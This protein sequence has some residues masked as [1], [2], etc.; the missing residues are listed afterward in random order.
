MLETTKEDVQTF[1]RQFSM[2]Q[3]RVEEAIQI[4][5][6]GRLAEAEKALLVI[7]AEAEDL[8]GD[9]S[10]HL[11]HV[12]KPLGIV[13]FRQGRFQEAHEAFA[14]M[15]RLRFEYESAVQ[16]QTD[17]EWLIQAQLALQQNADANATL[18]RLIAVLES[19]NAAIDSEIR[20]WQ[21]QAAD[22]INVPR[23]LSSRGAL[24]SMDG[25][26]A[27]R[28]GGTI[29]IKACASC[30]QEANLK[31]CGGCRAAWFCSPACQK[32]CW[33]A[34]KAVCRSMQ[35]KDDLLQAVSMNVEAGRLLSP[36]TPSVFC[37]SLRAAL[38]DRRE[39]YFFRIGDLCSS[40][41]LAQDGG[42]RRFLATAG[43]LTCITVFAWAPVSIPI[44][45]APVAVAAH[46]PLCSV[47]RGVRACVLTGQDLDRAL[48]PLTCELRRCFRG[49]DPATVHVTLVGGHRAS[50]KDPENAFKSIL[51]HLPAMKRIEDDD[52]R[53]CFSWYVRAACTAAGLAKAVFDVRF[54]NLFE[55][56]RCVDSSIELRLRQANMRFEVAALDTL[57]GHVVTHT[58]HA[59]DD[60]ILSPV[61]FLRQAERYNTLPLAGEPLRPVSHRDAS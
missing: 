29:I 16:H 34:H 46:V 45:G 47:L 2:L 55:G 18:R 53:M 36:D 23:S 12:L 58:R 13:F 22:N 17:L 19:N 52:P 26:T 60:N 38:V 50:D 28:N 4:R 15:D 54:L 25:A 59:N 49:L 44:S 10:Q 30:G 6:V 40:R 3:N 39:T 33:P 41:L 32:A 61:E 27:A 35:K 56:E 51:T 14:R 1:L 7:L 21:K 37:E 5:N 42:G 24:N 20:R 8:C 9:N 57:T 48:A 43:I 11:S 31:I